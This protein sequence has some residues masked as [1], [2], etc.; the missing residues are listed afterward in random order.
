[1]NGI[2]LFTGSGIE[3]Y[4]WSGIDLYTGSGKELY[5]GSG[6]ELCTGSWIELCTGSGIELCTGSGI[7]LCTGSGMGVVFFFSRTGGCTASHVINSQ[8]RETGVKVGQNSSSNSHSIYKCVMALHPP[9]FL[10]LLSPAPY[11]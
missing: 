10:L 8:P 9:K 4:T 6:I 2:D 5:S 7:V 1:V 11:P 3:L